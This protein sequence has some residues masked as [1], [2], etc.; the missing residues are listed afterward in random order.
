MQS[1]NSY[2]SPLCQF[3][4][5][6]GEPNKGIHS[7]RIFGLAAVDLGLSLLLASIIAV[8]SYS[9]LSKKYEMKKYNFLVLLLISILIVFISGIKAHQLFC[10]ETKL[11]KAL[12]VSPLST[13]A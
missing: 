8:V 7:Y 13:F 3:S 9:F 11:N 6:L 5:V 10:V 4:S 12:G 1:K 2:P